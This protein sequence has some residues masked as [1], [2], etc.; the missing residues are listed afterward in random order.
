MRTRFASAL[1]FADSHTQNWGGIAL[2]V[3]NYKRGVDSL[4]FGTNSAGLT[5]T[6]LGLIQ[7]HDYL[8]VP[9]KIDAAGFVTPLPPPTL[10]IA[11]E[12]PGAVRVTWEAINGRNYI[13]QCKTNSH[14]VYWN[15]NFVQDVVAT[16]NR[17]SF[18]DTLSENSRRFYRVSL[19]PVAVGN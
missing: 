9:G 19:W 10:S 5:A 4:C 18:V 3:V 15:T 16:N 7:F 17:A 6:Q 8:D 14:E 11:V 2:R 13:V 12:S 1:A